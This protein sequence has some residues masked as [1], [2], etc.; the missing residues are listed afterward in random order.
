MKNIN[1]LA[2]AAVLATN[3]ISTAPIQPQKNQPLNDNPTEISIVNPR[4]YFFEEGKPI[5]CLYYKNISLGSTQNVYPEKGTMAIGLDIE[6]SDKDGLKAIGIGYGTPGRPNEGYPN[7]EKKITINMFANGYNPLFFINNP[8]MVDVYDS[9]MNRTLK[10][11]TLNDILSKGKEMKS[12]PVIKGKFGL[13]CPDTH[14]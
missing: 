11:I 14:I 13:I 4:Y 2:F 5:I 3:L 1:H 12:S 6:I 8:L 9:K 10:S 7:N